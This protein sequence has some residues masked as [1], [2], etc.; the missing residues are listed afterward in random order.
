MIESPNAEHVAKL[1]HV[2]PDWRDAVQHPQWRVSCEQPQCSACLTRLDKNELV[3]SAPRE[4][5][6]DGS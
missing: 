2:H 5:Q 6:A 3:V 4:T 1:M